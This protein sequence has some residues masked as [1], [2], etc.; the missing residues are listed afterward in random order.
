MK[1]K[2]EIELEIQLKQMEIKQLRNREI[3]V[4][5]DPFYLEKLARDK[6]GYAKPNEIIYK[7]D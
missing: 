3:L 6:L 4:Q 1:K 5:T 7:F 2:I